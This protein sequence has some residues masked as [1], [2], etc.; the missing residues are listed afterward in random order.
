MLDEPDWKK[1]AKSVGIDPD[2]YTMRERGA[3]ENLPWDFIDVGVS[4]EKLRERY[5]KSLS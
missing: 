5:E 2:F 1:A 4:R 3:V